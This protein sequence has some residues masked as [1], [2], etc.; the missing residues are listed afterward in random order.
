MRKNFF[1]RVLTGLLASTIVF[2]PAINSITVLAEPD[3]PDIQ[4]ETETEDTGLLL[5][6]SLEGVNLSI[7]SDALVEEAYQNEDGYYELELSIGTE[8]VV[9]AHEGF[10][11]ATYYVD[12]DSGE[13]LSS[14]VTEDSARLIITNHLQGFRVLSMDT[15]EETVP[16]IPLTES[17]DM[18][19]AEVFDA[20]VPDGQHAVR[21]SSI[22]G[23]SV[24]ADD[25]NVDDLITERPDGYLGRNRFYVHRS[26]ISK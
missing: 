25:E 1:K 14:D 12:I 17:L 24:Y 23:L 15:A 21:F 18:V 11:V 8:V 5:F 13:V 22:I 7:E 3:A 16:I 10:Q 2:T 6:N 26:I 20:S 4:F 19:D 9:E